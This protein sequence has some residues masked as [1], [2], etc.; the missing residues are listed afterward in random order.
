MVAIVPKAFES[1]ITGLGLDGP[2]ADVVIDSDRVLREFG[3]SPLTFE[4]RDKRRIVLTLTSQLLLIHRS[5]NGSTNCT[6]I[7]DA[8]SAPRLRSWQRSY[9]LPAF[10]EVISLS[11]RP[12][13]HAVSRSSEQRRW[14]ERPPGCSTAASHCCGSRSR[15]D[16]VEGPRRQG[17]KRDVGLL[18]RSRR[19][20]RTTSRQTPAKVQR[21]NMQVVVRLVYVL[22]FSMKVRDT[23]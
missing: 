12:R 4:R 9:A 22:D 5:R 3:A 14:P 1:G 18:P 21:K 23:P 2:R 20:N 6:Q 11:V 13:A 7:A 19:P 10:C 8:P 15:S 17:P 16:P